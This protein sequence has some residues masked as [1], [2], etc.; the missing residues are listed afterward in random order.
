MMRWDADGGCHLTRE[1]NLIRGEC[2]IYFRG[3]GWQTLF[4][5]VCKCFIV[6]DIQHMLVFFIISSLSS[7]SRER[8]Y[9]VAGGFVVGF[10]KRL[11][12]LI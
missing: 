8:K 10:S 2:R 5:C 12:D 4:G 3:G 1:M 9:Q 7:L 6:K 11:E